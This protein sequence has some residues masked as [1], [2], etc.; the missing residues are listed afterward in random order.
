MGAPPGDRLRHRA[1]GD[2]RRLPRPRLRRAG[3]PDLVRRMGRIGDRRRSL[4]L[5]RSVRDLRGLRVSPGAHRRAGNGRSGGQ[6]D[7]RPIR[8]RRAPA[9]A[10]RP[11]PDR[12]LHR[13]HAARAPL[14]PPARSRSRRGLR[15]LP[16]FGRTHRDRGGVLPGALPGGVEPRAA[17]PVRLVLHLP[18]RAPGRL[19]GAPPV[20]LAPGVAPRW[21]LRPL[22]D[23]DRAPHHEGER[24][25]LAGLL[26]L[27]LLGVRRL[28][29]GRGAEAPS[30]RRTTL[31][32]GGLGV[33][34]AGFSSWCRSLATA[35]IWA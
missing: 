13:L 3:A 16:R 24:P 20:R 32:L 7:H 21:F 10:P 8:R 31:V 5:P 18:L 9:R 6:P 33:A 35:A 26:P 15:G 1:P 2:L 4:G 14:R 23:L 27:L 19:G 29:R 17:H 22:G 30:T 25:A 12:N 11:R 34:F 28:G